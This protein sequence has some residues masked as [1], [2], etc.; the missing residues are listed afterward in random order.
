MGSKSL[1]FIRSDGAVYMCLKNATCSD[2]M[3]CILHSSLLL[4]ITRPLCTYVVK[5]EFMV[6]L[7]TQSVRTYALGKFQ[8]YKNRVALHPVVVTYMQSIYCMLQHSY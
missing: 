3:S 1:I 8:K 4:D 5:W 6:P 2:T 7:S